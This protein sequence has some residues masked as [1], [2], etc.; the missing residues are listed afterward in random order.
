MKITIWN[1]KNQSF[2][3]FA[4]YTFYICR[5]VKMPFYVPV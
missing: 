5:M 2:C 4:W 3:N 1:W